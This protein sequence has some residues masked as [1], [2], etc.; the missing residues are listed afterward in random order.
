MGSIKALVQYIYEQ[1]IELE[2]KADMEEFVKLSRDLGIL[3]LAQIDVKAC[4]KLVERSQPDYVSEAD[5]E[6]GIVDPEEPSLKKLEKL[7]ANIQDKIQGL[8]SDISDSSSSEDENKENPEDKKIVAQKLVNKIVR[9][10]KR[11]QRFK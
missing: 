4:E 6:M 10:K 8:K 5:L 2:T 1:P 11:S 7:A 9:R 3:S